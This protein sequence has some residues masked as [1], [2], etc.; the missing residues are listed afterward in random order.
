MSVELWLAC[1]SIVVTIA[2]AA[3][4]PLLVLIFRTGNDIAGKLGGIEAE[5]ADLNNHKNDC[6]KDRRELHKEINA[7][8]LQL[9]QTQR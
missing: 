5:I 4:V 2:T 8:N 6:T 7:V 1:I 3:G 9:A